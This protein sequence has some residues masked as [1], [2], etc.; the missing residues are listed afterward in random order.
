MLTMAE[1]ELKLHIVVFKTL[2]RLAII[3]FK[4]KKKEK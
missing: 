4:K 3:C 1:K 2:F